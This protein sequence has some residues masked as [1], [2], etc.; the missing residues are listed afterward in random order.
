MIRMSNKS[1]HERL[2]VLVF[3]FRVVRLHRLYQRLSGP[4]TL[5]SIIFPTI[6]NEDSLL[7]RGVSRIP[8]HMRKRGKPTAFLYISRCRWGTQ[9]ITK[10]RSNKFFDCAI[11]IDLPLCPAASKASLTSCIARRRGGKGLTM[12]LSHIIPKHSLAPLPPCPSKLYSLSSHGL[13]MTRGSRSHGLESSIAFVKMRTA[14]IEFVIGPSTE[15]IDS[16]P[17]RALAAPA[18]GRRS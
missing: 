17:S 5:S 8:V 18:Y 1:L 9:S 15:E 4:F 3:I 16:W 2:H 10:E 11:K 14:A 7:V 13:R 12:P 6:S